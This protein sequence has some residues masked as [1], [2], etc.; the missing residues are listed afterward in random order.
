[1][2]RHYGMDWLRVGAFA[3]LILYHVG[4]VFVPWGFHIK[5]AEPLV[6]AEIPM[7][8]TNPWRL[9]LLFV[10]SGYASRALV[11]KSPSVGAFLRSRNARL[12]IPL[13]FGVTVVVPPQPWIELVAQ[14]GY[15]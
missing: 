5:T 8:L 9:S 10:V 1:M 14:H 6:W 15:T 2:E 12:L 13:A 4:M 11:M 7:F 3:L